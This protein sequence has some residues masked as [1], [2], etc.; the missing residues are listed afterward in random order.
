M[1]WATGTSA[2]V[3]VF[4]PAGFDVSRQRGVV[5]VLREERS[6]PGTTA[7]RRS[8]K[9]IPSIPSTPPAPAPASSRPIPPASSAHPRPAAAIAATQAQ[10]RTRKTLPSGARLLGRSELR[11]V[12][13]RCASEPVAQVCP[14]AG[15]DAVPR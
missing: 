12:G 7:I 2:L 10:A 5:V 1:D 6:A 14:C 3:R 11:Q 8:L 13:R 4:L 9:S 15:V